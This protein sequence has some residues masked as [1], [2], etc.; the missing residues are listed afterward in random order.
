[1]KKDK[2]VNGFFYI[3]FDKCSQELQNNFINNIGYPILYKDG[4]GQYDL[5]NNL[6]QEFIC[7]YDCIKKL[8]I[9]DKTLAK[10]LDKD[11]PYNNHYYRRLP[12]KIF[13]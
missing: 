5:S 4:V 3:L 2:P 10:T 7:K 8:K 6:I 13:C 12:E 9:S 1:M 11:I